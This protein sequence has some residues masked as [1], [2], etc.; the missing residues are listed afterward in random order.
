M[1]ASALVNIVIDTLTGCRGGAHAEMGVYLLFTYSGLKH[2]LGVM[3]TVN[4]VR[5]WIV[6]Y[7]KEG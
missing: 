4:L 2:W 1:G 6:R 7:L 3:L 5:L